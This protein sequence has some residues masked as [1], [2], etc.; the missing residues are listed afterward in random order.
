MSLIVIGAWA[1]KNENEPIIA[2]TVS[3]ETALGFSLSAAEDNLSIQIDWGGGTLTDKN[4]NKANTYIRYS[5]RNKNHQDLCGCHYNQRTL[6]VLLQLSHRS[7][8]KQMYSF[9]KTLSE[10]MH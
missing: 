5:L 10:R 1:E 2:L 7:R 4:I 9:K 6:P 3:K 8:P